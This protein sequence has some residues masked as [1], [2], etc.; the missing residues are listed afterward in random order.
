VNALLLGLCFATELLG[1][2]DLF[3]LYSPVI[4]RLIHRTVL[5]PIE[6][7]A[8][9]FALHTW[10]NLIIVMCS[11]KD[12]YNLLFSPDRGVF[13][14]GGCSNQVREAVPLPSICSLHGVDLS[15]P[16]GSGEWRENTRRIRGVQ[17]TTLY[18][19]Y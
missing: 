11:L 3:P 1:L 10:V 15:V 12:S 7:K 14:D 18:S 13:C 4:L 17:Y 9:Y 19:I 8:Q 16:R 2:T 6:A 5:T